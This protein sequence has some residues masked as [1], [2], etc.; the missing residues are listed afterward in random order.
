MKFEQLLATDCYLCG[1]RLTQ[2]NKD[3]RDACSLNIENHASGEAT[4]KFDKKYSG[5]GEKLVCEHCRSQLPVCIHNCFTCGLPL[6]DSLTG[7]S[8]QQTCGQCLISSPVFS[9][10]ISAFHYEAPI[11]HFITQLKFSAQFQLLPIMVDFLVTKLIQGYQNEP[12]PQAL[13]AIPLHPKKQRSRGFNQ[14]RL[15]ANRLSKQLNIPVIDRGVERIKLTRAQSGLDAKERK[16]NIKGAFRVS[17]KL[18]EHIAVIDDVITT[19]L[20]VSEFS[21]TALSHGCQKIHAWS[22]ARAYEI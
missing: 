9:R 19:G 7:A 10:L 17:T 18:P 12:F 22:I 4:S 6:P 11:N 21:S 20:T 16:E 2:Q 13:V 3:L 14:A 8:N 1:C 5:I 15:I